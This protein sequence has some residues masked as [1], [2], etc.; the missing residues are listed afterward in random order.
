[1]NKEN[2]INEQAKLEIEETKNQQPKK[3]LKIVEKYRQLKDKYQ[4]SKLSKV[5]SIFWW[6]VIG[7]FVTFALWTSIDRWTGYNFPFIKGYRNTVIISDSMST[8]HPDRAE[9][10]SGVD[11][12]IQ[13]NDIVTS[14]LVSFEELEVYDI[15]IV[16]N[17]NLLICHRIV[18]KGIKDDGTK[19]LITRGDANFNIDGYIE[20]NRQNFKG[21]VI[22]IRPGNGE[23][24]RFIQSP[25]GL[26]ALSAAIT[27]YATTGIIL[28]HLEEKRKKEA[29]EE[30]NNNSESTNLKDDGIKNIEELV[31]PPK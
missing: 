2:N 23:F 7:C 25:Y 29:L 19:Y 3:K 16:K 11:N 8:V 10:L 9:F 26:L 14:V 28:D 6:I 13:R 21:K 15:V 12:R 17:G 4:K 24:V 18:E 27:I 20:F 31:V 22:K 30:V 5:I 1:M